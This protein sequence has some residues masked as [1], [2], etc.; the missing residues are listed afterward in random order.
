GDFS[1]RG[2]QG[3]AHRVLV[4]IRRAVDGLAA[5]RSGRNSVEDREAHRICGRGICVAEGKLFALDGCGH[6]A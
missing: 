1:L 3:R 4:V 5:P 6:E 2:N